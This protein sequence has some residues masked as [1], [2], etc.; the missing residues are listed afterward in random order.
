MGV[1]SVGCAVRIG[2]FEL[3]SRPMVVCEIGAAHNG[4]K[5][6]ALLLIEAAKRGGADAVKI[7]AFLPDTI[8]RKFDRPEF[9]IQAGP[10]FGWHLH[11]LYTQAHMPRDWF[12]EIFA[13]GIQ[14]DIPIFPSVFSIEDLQ[15]VQQFEPIAYKIASFEMV[16]PIL[17]KAAADTGK[18]LILS[19]GMAEW[20]EIRM[21]M[22]AAGRAPSVWL[23]CVSSYPTQVEK[24]NLHM[25]DVLRREQSWVGLSD[26]TIGTEVAMMAVARGACL[27]EKHITLTPGGGGLDDHFA[28]DADQFA[29][30]VEAVHRAHASIGSRENPR[31]DSEHRALRRSLYVVEDITEGHKFTTMN[32]ASI[33]PGL[34]LPPARMSEV[35]GSV[36]TMDIPAGTPLAEHMVRKV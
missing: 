36:A 34:G 7:Q 12:T 10:W 24:A 14:L 30:F 1:G 23:H 20:G 26:H 27:I 35:F 31:D 6:A 9:V 2:S 17:I 33:R 18:P 3:G 11:D 15:F 16:D 29:H 21:A 4:S 25:M 13:L 32:V 19:T 22:R 28:T 8:T 5:E